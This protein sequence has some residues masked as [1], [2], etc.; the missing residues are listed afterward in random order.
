M[1]VTIDALGIKYSSMLKKSPKQETVNIIVSE[2]NGLTYIGTK[3]H[4]SLEDKLRIVKNIRE[5]YYN[6]KLLEHTDNSALLSLVDMI[7]NSIGGQ[8]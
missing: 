5:K 4:L 6:G 1:S 3:K 8:L 7:E 2:I